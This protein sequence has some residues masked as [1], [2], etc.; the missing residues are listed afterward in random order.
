MWQ[1]M[2]G[3]VKPY[4]VIGD[5]KWSDYALSANVRIVAATWN[6]AAVS[7]I[8]T[9]CRTAGSWPKTEPGS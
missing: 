6:W 3:I 4:T 1:Y 8:R 5:Q 2:Q 9:S 7:A